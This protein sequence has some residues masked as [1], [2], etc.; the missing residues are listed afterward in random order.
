MLSLLLLISSC[1][2]GLTFFCL[3]L[4]LFIHYKKISSSLPKTE[5]TYNKLLAKE[6]LLGFLNFFF[7][8][9]GQLALVITDLIL[10][11]WSNT[12][13]TVYIVPVGISLLLGMSYWFFVINNKRERF[14]I[15]L[16][17]KARSPRYKDY[18]LIFFF[19][20]MFFSFGN[21]LGL[22]LVFIFWALL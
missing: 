20:G 14:F 8:L 2:L 9:L 17:E 4:C 13:F 7:F 15:T 3:D 1:L 10:G 22:L 6:S 19:E 11:D 12:R 16:T 18:G 5:E 21:F